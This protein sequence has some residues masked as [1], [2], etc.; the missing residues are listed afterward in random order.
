MSHKAYS[1]LRFSTPEQ[2]RGDSFRRQ[3]ALAHRWCL[4]NGVELDESLSFQDLGVSAY[5]GDNAETGRLGDFL[6][7]V[8]AGVVPQGSYL[9][10]E[11]LDRISRLVPLKALNVLTSIVYAGITLVTLNDKAEYT[12]ENLN[13]DS[14]KLMMAIMYFVRANEESATKSK[15]L[16]AAWENKRNN[17]LERPLTTI[18]PAWI[19]MKR[20]T[21]EM[22]LIPERVKVLERIFQMTLEGV[23]MSKIARTLTEEHVPTWGTGKVWQKS[24]ISKIQKNPAV[25]GGYVPHVVEH[26]GTK[27]VRTPVGLIEGYYPPAIAKDVFDA[28]Q[29][30]KGGH[31]QSRAKGATQ[32]IIAGL[33]A[34]PLCGG[35]MLR[36]SKGARSKPKLVCTNA[37]NGAGCTYHSVTLSFVEDSIRHHAEELAQVPPAAHTLDDEWESLSN[38]LTGVEEAIASTLEAIAQKPLKPLLDMLEELQANKEKIDGRLGELTLKIATGSDLVLQRRAKDLV[39]TLNA[40]ELDLGLANSQL[41]QLFDKVVINYPNG[42]LDFLYKNGAS[43]QIFFAE[44]F[45]Q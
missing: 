17:A 44:G 20:D 24:Y 16:K 25:Y 18:T 10:V 37:K 7:A 28:V 40:E 1:Y 14:M 34:C 11:S 41:K 23:G 5:R 35:T 43:T 4:D 36:I 9:L 8:R 3:T 12:E 6:E 15:R 29:A 26:E 2:S 19:A 31:A 27:A 39:N 33:G 38:D 42:T 22:Q 32:N 30:M 21:G 13:A 45:R